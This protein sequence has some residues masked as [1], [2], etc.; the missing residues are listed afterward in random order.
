MSRSPEDEPELYELAQA[1]RY[2]ERQHPDR[3]RIGTDTSPDAEAV[4]FRSWLD[5]G[6]SDCPVKEYEPATADQP[7][8]LTVAVEG[9][10]GPHGVL[11]PPYSTLA[12]Q[13]L[14][15]RDVTMRNWLDVFQHRLLSFRVRAWEKPRLEVVEDRPGTPHLRAFVG[16][17]NATN[18]AA[19]E[20]RTR[21]AGVFRR[22]IRTADQ[23]RE[24]LQAQ[25]GL[26]VEV[27]QLA[28]KRLYL[29]GDQRCR[30]PVASDID[31]PLV[32]NGTS[33]LGR[34]VLEVQHQLHIKLGPMDYAQFQ[35]YQLGGSD[36]PRVKELVWTTV[37]LE[38]EVTLQFWLQAEE[39]PESR[40]ERDEG[41]AL[42]LGRNVW[43]AAHGAA[44][45]VG[46]VTV[47]IPMPDA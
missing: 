44:A 36:W 16:L 47:T 23:I 4:R 31:S 21:H 3:G 17:D 26:P 15:Q 39:V 34:S 29:D 28:P 46:D 25:L 42:C 38:F 2:A 35:R 9:L 45:P 12:R 24:V 13:R 43:L 37:G 27:V 32:L 41:V 30:L 5:S 6:S 1:V 11:P 19:D 7:A 20:L 14:R 18:A 8:E 10:L 33:P 22:T 40:L